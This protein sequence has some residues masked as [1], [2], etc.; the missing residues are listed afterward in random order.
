MFDLNQELRSI[1]THEL[2]STPKLMTFLPMLPSGNENS[3][4]ELNPVPCPLHTYLSRSPFLANRTP[5][6]KQS[7]KVRS[8]F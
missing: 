5:P 6:N 8:E 2:I 1:C 7:F 4:C 3:E